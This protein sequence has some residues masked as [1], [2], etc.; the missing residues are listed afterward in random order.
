[1]NKNILVILKKENELSKRLL[2]FSV[3]I[4]K[5]M[6]FLPKQ[7]EYNV[8]RYQLIKSAT[9]VGANYEEAQSASSKADFKNKVNISLKE[10]SESKYWLKIISQ[11]HS[12]NHN[13]NKLDILIQESIELDN[14]L[15]AIVKNT[16]I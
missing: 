12:N 8:I 11:V 7:T 15:G 13:R 1:M 9:S 14:I 2:K 10:M 5:L 3:D 6:R 4:I 16:K